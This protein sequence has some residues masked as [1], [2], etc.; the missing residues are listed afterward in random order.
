MRHKKLIVV[1]GG[2]VIAAAVAK[3]AR[4]RR[5]CRMRHSSNQGHRR[6]PAER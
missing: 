5:P 3:Q 1:I 4:L 6:V 2:G